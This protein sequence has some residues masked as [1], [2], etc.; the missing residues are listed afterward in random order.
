MNIQNK[1]QQSLVF[2]ITFINLKCH[3]VYS[4]RFHLT[5]VSAT[6]HVHEVSEAIRIRNANVGLCSETKYRL[7]DKIGEMK[8]SD[9]PDSNEASSA[10][11]KMA[12]DNFRTEL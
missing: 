1:R 2:S 5:P 8:W 9:Q 3:I 11:I 7:T 6:I 4:W 10:K 12:A